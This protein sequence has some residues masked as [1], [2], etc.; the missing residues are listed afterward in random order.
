MV[1]KIKC[2]FCNELNKIDNKFCVYCGKEL[3]IGNGKSDL[4]SGDVSNSERAQTT[5]EHDFIECPA[6]NA[7]NYKESIECGNCGYLLNENIKKS[8]HISNDYKK[9]FSS[10]DE[11]KYRK[12]P[13]C[14]N[15]LSSNNNICNIC[16]YEFIVIDYDS[17]DD[18][19][20]N[21]I[22]KEYEK[23]LDFFKE[24]N[25]FNDYDIFL[26]KF[27]EFCVE[28]NIPLYFS[29]IGMVQ[30]PQCLKFFC[31]I[32]PHFI[33]NH[34]CPHCSYKFDFDS[35]EEAYCAN[36][37][38]SVKKHQAICE[39]GHEM[40][41]VSADEAYC[42]NCGRS[43]KANQTVCECGYELADI[44]CPKCGTAHPYTTSYCTSCGN[45]LWHPDVVFSQKITP[46]G[47]IY[48]NNNLVLDS[49]FLKKE[50]LK[51]PYQINDRIYTQ[52]LHSEYLKHNQIIDEICSRWW[53]VCQ[54]N[55][56]SCLNKIDA[57]KD[58]C[59]TCNIT[60]YSDYY[61][62]RVNDLKI[63]ENNYIESERSFNELNNLKWNYK[64]NETDVADYLNSLSPK[65][66]ESQLEYRQRLFR[67]WWEISVILYLIKIE[68]NRYFNNI[69]MNCS[70]EFEQYN[71]YCPSCGMKKDV[72]IL[73]VLLN[74][75]YVETE[76]IPRQY[77]EFSADLEN[78]CRDN[79]GDISY[80]EDGIVG[81][82][83]CS[84]YFHYLTPDFI[85][86]HRC[87]HCGAHF[88]INANIYHDEWDLEGLSY[89]E[90]IE[91]FNNGKPL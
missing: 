33:L 57:L 68:W 14:G 80:V 66:G 89:E 70:S 86:T 16:G 51:N 83:S 15:I 75:D 88:E 3:E 74:D 27:N 32:S 69:C 49:T 23:N 11:K 9:S 46:H 28:N 26:S 29:N 53:I 5:K 84:N 45:T 48:E 36:C 2:S 50:A 76:T 62:D 18:F 21:P 20:K 34:D 12:C 43:V 8:F 60:H 25:K 87:P 1:N 37:G 42:L 44:K 64:L 10:S 72:P 38:K 19:F 82:P 78:I 81:C 90:Y 7:L 91:Q 17:S 13:K 63:I 77:D 35:A 71:L 47:C 24:I 6:C 73:S 55:C 67:E 79:G 61:N 39:C 54:I 85:N 56:K 31:F 65:I 52:T 58:N 40:D 22:Y 41:C 59:P 30:C 4:F